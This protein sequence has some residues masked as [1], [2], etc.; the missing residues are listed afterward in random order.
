MGFSRTS[1]KWI[2]SYLQDRSLQVIDKNSR[3]EPLSINLGVPQGSVLG[4]L[5]FNLY[6]NDVKSYLPDDVYHILYADDLQVYFQAS[7][8]DAISATEKLAKIVRM[9]TDWAADLSLRL[10]HDKMKA[11]YFGTRTF[12]DQLNNL[13][14]LSVDLGKGN[15][16]SL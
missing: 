15:F 8:E 5:L 14:Y 4:P 10:N 2:A 16:Y 6:I 3:S 7:P 12:V 11:I 9:V 1:L 13:N